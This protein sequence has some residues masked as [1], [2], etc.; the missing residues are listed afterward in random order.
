LIVPGLDF[1][2]GSWGLDIKPY[3]KELIPDKKIKTGWIS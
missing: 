2:D 1:S 3:I